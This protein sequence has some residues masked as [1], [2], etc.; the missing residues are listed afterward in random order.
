MAYFNYHAKIKR[1]LR[2]GK[3]REVKLVE[4]YRGISPAMLL[5]F[6]GERPMPIREY[7]FEEYAS[8]LKQYP[9]PI[10]NGEQERLPFSEEE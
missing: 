1:L 10:R 9:V 8:L 7:R 2:E 5:Y 3:L 6:E 4:S